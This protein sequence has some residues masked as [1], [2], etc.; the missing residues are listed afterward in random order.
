MALLYT[1]RAMPPRVSQHH[2]VFH[3]QICIRNRTAPVLSWHYL[4]HKP[5]G[6]A[7]TDQEEN[8]LDAMVRLIQQ[9]QQQQP[10][11]ANGTGQDHRPGAPQKEARSTVSEINQPPAQRRPLTQL[12]PTR[13]QPAAVQAAAQAALQVCC[14]EVAHPSVIESPFA[15]IRSRQ[16]W[17]RMYQFSSTLTERTKACE[18]CDN[19]GPHDRES[20]HQALVKSPNSPL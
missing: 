10:P 3:V 14:V 5:S 9:E 16:F 2:D 18:L 20:V 11:D 15:S 4:Q 19:H 1:W 17:R 8:D 7:S 6:Y 12:S 13:A